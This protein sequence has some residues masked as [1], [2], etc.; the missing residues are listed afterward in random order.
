MGDQFRV[1]F[2]VPPGTKN[3]NRLS[4]PVSIPVEEYIKFKMGMRDGNNGEMAYYV[5]KNFLKGVPL[6]GDDITMIAAV[7]NPMYIFDIDAAIDRGENPLNNGSQ[8]GSDNGEYDELYSLIEKCS[9]DGTDPNEVINNWRKR[10]GEE[11]LAV[12]ANEETDE[13]IFDKAAALFE[14]HR[15]KTLNADNEKK[16][17][18][19]VIKQLGE[20]LKDDKEESTDVFKS[21]DKLISRFYPQW[22]NVDKKTSDIVHLLVVMLFILAI[23]G[24]IKIMF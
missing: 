12:N 8:E 10:H 24:L 6:S 4:S 13:D 14:K 3:S 11:V 5:S 9:E 16:S 23:L 22:E 18:K 15:E 7:G 19:S 17:L 2:K 20:E 21:V 1:M